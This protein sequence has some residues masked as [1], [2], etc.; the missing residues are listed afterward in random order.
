MRRKNATTLRATALLLIPLTCSFLTSACGSS[1]YAAASPAYEPVA[2]ESAGGEYGY[3][4]AEMAMSDAMADGDGRM[5][6]MPTVQTMAVH[7]ASARSSAPS[8]SPP[9]PPSQKTAAL[10]PPTAPNAPSTEGPGNAQDQTVLSDAAPIQRVLVYTGTFWMA[11]FEVDKAIDRVEELARSA[12]GF[13]AHRN[14]SSV[15]VRVP[16]AQFDDTVKEVAGMGDVMR[17]NVQVEDVTEEFVD[18]MLRLK[19][20]RQVRDRIASLLANAKTVEESIKVE[21]ELR[22]LS[23]EIERLE[24]R[25]KYLSSMA[26]FSTITVHFQTTRAT[27]ARSKFRLP[28]PWLDSLGLGR[29]MDLH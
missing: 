6:A 23:G 15:T 17:R 9:P 19:N 11:V 29:L 25:L 26:R 24:G 22:R 3:A 1:M 10:A 2:T 7:G 13:M 28:F 5:E 16:A 14:E 21:L 18:V 4:Q 27:E 20:A 12:G 8:P